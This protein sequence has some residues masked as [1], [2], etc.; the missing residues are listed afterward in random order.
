MKLY[1]LL[2]ESSVSTNE[3]ISTLKIMITDSDSQTS[4]FLYQLSKKTNTQTVAQELYQQ[5]KNTFDKITK[6]AETFEYLGGGSKGDAFNLG[7]QILKL[8]METPWDT[9]FSSKERAEK[10]ATDLYGKLPPTKSTPT[11]PS[12]QK[13]V[14]ESSSSTNDES[15]AN[16]V[17]MIYDQGTLKFYGKEISWVIMEKLEI[18]TNE[19]ELELF[20]DAVT[21]KFNNGYNLQDMLSQDPLDDKQKELIKDIGEELRLKSNWYENLITGMWKLYGKGIRDFHA[22]NIG[23]RRTG[24]THGWETNPQGQGYLVFFD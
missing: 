7:N 3:I 18:P 8:E 15:I 4:N 1:K 16:Y 6:N 13:T 12:T 11:P 17:P 23:I 5:N 14:R 20:L 22:G 10:A 24:A 2:F 9:R 21:E 19:L